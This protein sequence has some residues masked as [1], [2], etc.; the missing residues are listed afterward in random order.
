MIKKDG[1]III[2]SK[3]YL[4]NKSLFSTFYFSKQTDGLLT[5]QLLGDFFINSYMKQ[6]VPK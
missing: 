1:F 5:R 2:Y 4:P 3:H 6:I